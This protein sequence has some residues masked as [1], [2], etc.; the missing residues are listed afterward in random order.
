[1]RWYEREASS[2][3][4]SANQHRPWDVYQTVFGQL[5]EKCRAVAPIKKKFTPTSAIK[6]YANR[7][8]PEYSANPPS[9]T[10]RAPKRGLR[11]PS[12]DFSQDFG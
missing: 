4:S 11:G 1:M 8:T 12:P 3:N 10:P 7:T 5:L 9:R 6:R 2:V